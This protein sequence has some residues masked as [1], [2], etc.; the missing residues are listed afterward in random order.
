MDYDI[1]FSGVEIVEDILGRGPGR[2]VLDP[3][4]E[5]QQRLRVIAGETTLPPR[6]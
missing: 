1:E 6:V 5:V 2:D 3:A 4:R